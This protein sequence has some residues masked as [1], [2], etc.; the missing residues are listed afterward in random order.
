MYESSLLGS[1]G[2]D[3]GNINVGQQVKSESVV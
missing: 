1:K 3:E 2:R